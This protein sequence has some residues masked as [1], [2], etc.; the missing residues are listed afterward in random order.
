MFELFSNFWKKS[1][2]NNPRVFP[3]TTQ[4][5]RR[6]ENVLF[7]DRTANELKEMV[8]SGS[9]C[10][11]VSLVR[12]LRVLESPTLKNRKL[13]E[14]LIASFKNEFGSLDAPVAIPALL[15]FV[16]KNDLGIAAKAVYYD[17]GSF[18]EEGIK[19][20][21][22]PV[23]GLSADLEIISYLPSAFNLTLEANQS[24]I[25]GIKSLT[26]DSDHFI[27]TE[28]GNIYQG[29]G[30]GGQKELQKYLSGMYVIDTVLVFE[31]ASEVLL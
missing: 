7:V 16:S 3:K 29:I 22:A 15:S 19:K 30:K 23:Q 27:S 4:L 17:Y 10:G 6:L 25:V 14:E 18:S 31:E 11:F 1:E 2:A 9:G 28:T 24:A 20:I 12:V 13:Q 8:E 5:R 21:L 26:K